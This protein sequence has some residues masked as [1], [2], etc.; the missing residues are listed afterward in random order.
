M[1]GTL[2][3]DSASAV[4]DHAKPIPSSAMPNDRLTGERNA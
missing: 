4:S 2:S 1:C 3:D